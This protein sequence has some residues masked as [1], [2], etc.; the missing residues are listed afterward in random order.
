MTLGRGAR[1]PLRQIGSWSFSQLTFLFIPGSFPTWEHLM[2]SP[3]PLLP[4][5][6][7][8]PNYH[9]AQHQLWKSL[10]MTTRKSVLYVQASYFVMHVIAALRSQNLREI[11][12]SLSFHKGSKRLR[13]RVWLSQGHKRT[14]LEQ[15][16]GHLI[17]A[18]VQ[19]CPY[20]V[21][22]LDQLQE[23]C[24]QFRII[25]KTQKHDAWGKG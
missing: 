13:E 2:L 25:K 1:R 4:S 20:N 22:C 15:S 24:S 6:P 9:A 21:V 12:D 16:W 19:G 7:L 14:N 5:P 17:L 11:P 3:T 10:L 8:M 18:L 23:V